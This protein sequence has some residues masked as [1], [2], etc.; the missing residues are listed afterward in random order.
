MNP[1]TLK[2]TR[3]SKSKR[4]RCVGEEP[5]AEDSVEISKT[6]AQV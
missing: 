2:E 4:K 3:S 5:V 6:H 1:Q